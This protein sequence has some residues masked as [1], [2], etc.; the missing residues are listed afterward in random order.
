MSVQHGQAE[1]C[2]MA[3]PEAVARTQ[4]NNS[5]SYASH[6]TENAENSVPV[7]TGK[8]QIGALGT[9]QEH[10]GAENSEHTEQKTYQW[11]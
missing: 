8:A 7:T 6:Q 1:M 11:C 9:S 10:Q 4:E 3:P 2:R 5:Q